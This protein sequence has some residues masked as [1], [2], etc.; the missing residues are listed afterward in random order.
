MKNKGMPFC[1]GTERLVLRCLSVPG[2]DV[3]S[4]DRKVRQNVW[5]RTSRYHPLL[6]ESQHLVQKFDMDQTYLE[7]I[8]SQLDRGFCELAKLEPILAS[9]VKEFN[10]NSGGLNVLLSA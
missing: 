2:Q 4:R 5:D 1:P 7:L 9:V 8:K 3:L 6:S 10:Q